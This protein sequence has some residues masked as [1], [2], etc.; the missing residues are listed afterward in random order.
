MYELD[1]DWTL[2][3]TRSFYVTRFLNEF[4]NHRSL[5]PYLSKRLEHIH[6]TE[7]HHYE[8]VLLCLSLTFPFR[9]FTLFIF[10]LTN[11]Q[12]ELNIYYENSY[13]L[14]IK[15]IDLLLKVNFIGKGGYK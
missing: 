5:G 8:F 10:I 7:Q 1:L 12:G 6:L 13:I 4:S 9:I 3:H 11:K 2:R 14:P 15:K